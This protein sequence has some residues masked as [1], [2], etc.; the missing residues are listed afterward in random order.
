MIDP[1]AVAERV[2]EVRSRISSAGS[3]P[4]QVRLIAVTKGFGPEAVAAAVAAGV[5]DVGENYAQELLAK[6]AHSQILGAE[7]RW[8][9][10]GRLQTN[11]VRGLLGVVDCWQ[12][13]D[14]LTLVK[15]LAARAGG[16]RILVQVNVSGE[17]QKGGCPPVEGPALVERA[18]A[19]GLDVLG[20]M[21]LGP[22]G[23][24]EMARPGFRMLA[25]MAG[26]LGL[27]ELSMGMTEDLEVAV[28]EG[29]TM[30]RVGRA[31]FGPRPGRSGD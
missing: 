31:L 8:H 17:R 23:P 30:I 13:V 22:D 15:E 14:R 27:R 24:P 16:A 1:A 25:T 18:A 4:D 19:L 6:W 10:I 26:E 2:Q 7:V 29:S 5:A 20:L 28:E 3:D 12:S 21:A 11:K 9:F